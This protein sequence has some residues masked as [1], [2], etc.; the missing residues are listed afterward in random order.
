MQGGERVRLVGRNGSGK[1]T[2]IKLII[3]KLKPHSGEVKLFGRAAYLDQDLS[4]LDPNESIVENIIE[5]AKILKRDA[6]AIAAN[7]GFRGALSN[8][9][10]GVLSGGELLKATLAAVL[11]NSD[12]PDLI[13]L[14]EPTNNLDVKSI[15]ILEDALNQYGGAILVV[16]HDE[17][18]INNL[19]IDR[20]E[21]L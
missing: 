18:F 15:S 5:S 13:I 4:L 10:A 14:D 9:K 7:F 2:L 21:Y 8:K 20:V 19:H 17:I 11:G 3:G 1:T 6:H 12:Q 16:S